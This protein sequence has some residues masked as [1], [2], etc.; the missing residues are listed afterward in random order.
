MD[1]NAAEELIKSIE[2]KDR[3]F[4]PKSKLLW[5]EYLSS[6]YWKNWRE[7]VRTFTSDK[8]EEARWFE[9]RLVELRS[10]ILEILRFYGK[11]YDDNYIKKLVKIEEKELE[12][13]TKDQWNNKKDNDITALQQRVT[14]LENKLTKTSREEQ[15]ITNLKQQISHLQNRLSNA[16][17]SEVN[18]KTPW[19]WI[20]GVAILIT[21]WGIW[22]FRK[23]RKSSSKH[24]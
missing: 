21:G 12:N 14:S 3:L 8:N 23:S 9:F 1:I 20:A 18:N 24:N 13:I 10:R 15:E 16:P 5:E 19:E 4:R 2:E 22:F 7:K 6:D 17:T 11:N